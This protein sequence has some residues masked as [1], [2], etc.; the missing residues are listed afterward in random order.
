MDGAMQK[1]GGRRRSKVSV[2]IK[3]KKEATI[4]NVSTYGCVGDMFTIVPLMTAELR[5]LTG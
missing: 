2:G 4:F 3:T 5:R 1:P